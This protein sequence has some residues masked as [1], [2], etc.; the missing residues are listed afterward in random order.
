[1]STLQ[2]KNGL[3][4]SAAY[5][6]SGSPQV[7]SG[8]GAGT[9]VINYDYVTSGVMLLNVTAGSRITAFFD[10]ATA[11]IQLPPACCQVNLNIKCR[12]VKI[13]AIGVSPKWSVCAALTTIDK[14]ELPEP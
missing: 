3:G 4:N 14:N 10:G 13:V 11:G 9:T 2:Y 5:Q 6:V 12:Q 7:D 1:M 8:S